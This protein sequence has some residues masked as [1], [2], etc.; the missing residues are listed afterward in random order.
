MSKRAITPE[1]LKQ[2][3][4][5]KK[6]LIIYE[7]IIVDNTIYYVDKHGNLCDKNANLIGIIKNN[8]D[9]RNNK[10]FTNSDII[11]FEKKYNY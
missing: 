6:K 5:N 1:Q 11:L 3:K 10:Q 8:S 9:L 4:E 7:E 2:I